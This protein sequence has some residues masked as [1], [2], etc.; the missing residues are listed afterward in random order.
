M[1]DDNVS[2]VGEVTVDGATVQV[3]EGN[4]SALRDLVGRDVAVAACPSRSTHTSSARGQRAQRSFETS[5]IPL[6]WGSRYGY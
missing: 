3:T 4:I 6:S 5:R 1:T 2:K